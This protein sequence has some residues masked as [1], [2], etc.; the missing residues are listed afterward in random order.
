MM[1]VVS[2]PAAAG[3]SSAS[4]LVIAQASMFLATKASSDGA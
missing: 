3:M 2:T 4:M 1:D